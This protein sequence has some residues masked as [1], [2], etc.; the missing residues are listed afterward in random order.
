MSDRH[1]Y[2]YEGYKYQL[3]KDFAVQLT[4]VPDK[5]I[6]TA[7]I[8]FDTTGYLYIKDGYA[9]DGPSWPAIDT[10]NFMRG[11]LVHDALYQLMRDKYLDRDKFR[12]LADLELKRLC[13]EDG[14]GAIRANYVYLGVRLG[15]RTAA[16]VRPALLVAP[17]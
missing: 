2:Y 8:R 13:M 5:F 1:I 4:F 15:G 16:T 12:N 10:P 9:W 3:K 6:Y 14:M 17:R 7:F 11:S